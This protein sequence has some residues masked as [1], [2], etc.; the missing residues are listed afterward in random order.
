M[1]RFD[2]TDTQWQRLEPLLPPQRSGKRGHPY[3]DH[4]MI[5][6]G[7]R[8]IIRTSAPWRDLPERYGPWQTCFDRFTRWQRDGTWTRVFQEITGDV[9]AQEPVAFAEVYVDS[10]STKVHPHAAGARTKVHRNARPL[11]GGNVSISRSTNR[12][13]VWA[14]AVAD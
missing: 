1:A 4:R 13:N 7:I 6:N 5:V 3:R 14:E 11:K 10:T 2:L 9:V 8:W 12:E